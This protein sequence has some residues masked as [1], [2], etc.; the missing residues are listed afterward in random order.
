MYIAMNRFR[1]RK[2]EE[3]AF[4]DIWARR[5]SHLPEVP[6]FVEFHLLRGPERED[7]TLYATHVVWE[8][9]ACFL[10]WTNSEA[11]RASHARAASSRDVYLG[12]PQFEGFNAVQ[13]VGKHGRTPQDQV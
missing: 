1:I 11:F 6:G 5:E 2:G 4:E 9:E 8:T 10:D 13:T 3:A 12:P 7:H